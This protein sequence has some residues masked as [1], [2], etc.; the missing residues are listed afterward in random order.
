MRFEHVLVVGAGQ[1]GGGIAQ[2]VAAHHPDR[3]VSL[4][5]IATSAAG[6]RAA[7]TPL[8][9]MDPTLAGG[10]PEPDWSDPE[11]VATYLV[12]QQRP[13]AGTLGFDEAA[14][15]R[16]ARLVVQRSHDVAAAGNHWQLAGDSD[17]FPMSA[18]RVPTLVMHGTADPLFPFPHGEALAAE[19]ASARLVPLP[20]M[21]H[22]HPPPALW[23][24]VVPALLAHTG[25]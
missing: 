20:G 12:E 13:Y 24:V 11:A 10:P 19:I 15:R 23:D 22:E 16:T 25:T 2:V 1:M 4:T 7:D 9:S 18:I 8:P 6:D 21:G 5:L 14:A 17:P 3:V